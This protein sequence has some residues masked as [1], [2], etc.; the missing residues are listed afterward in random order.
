[1]SP[2]EA[3]ALASAE[4]RRPPLAI[5]A[6]GVVRAYSERDAAGARLLRVAEIPNGIDQKL[7]PLNLGNT[8]E[9]L[10]APP[11]RPFE[12]GRFEDALRLADSKVALLSH[13]HVGVVSVADERAEWVLAWH[14]VASARLGD[15][16]TDPAGVDGTV[17]VVRAR[18]AGARQPWRTAAC[19]TPARAA[20]VLRRIEEVWKSA[21]DAAAARRGGPSGARGGGIF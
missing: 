17:V 3:R 20:E 15:P 9:T 1:L 12:G 13:R 7:N 2:A 10:N 18:D 6:D 8:L 21:R 14:E 4:P 16:R 19:G 5:R 11:K